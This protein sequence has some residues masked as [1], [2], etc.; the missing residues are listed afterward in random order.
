MNRMKVYLINHEIFEPYLTQSPLTDNPALIFSLSSVK[1]V[2][3]RKEPAPFRTGK[4]E[5]F[6]PSRRGVLRLR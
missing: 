4:E 6:K 5:G 3:A 1:S 2:T